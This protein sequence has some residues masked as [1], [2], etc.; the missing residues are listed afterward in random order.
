MKIS[1]T[2]ENLNKGLLIVGHIAGKNINLPIL[3][4]IF[5]KAKEKTLTVSA[6]NLEIGV[7]ADIRSKVE[8]NG[9][10]TVD[11]KLLSDYI[12]LLPQERIDLS[13]EE[14]YLK[15]NCQGQ[16]TK[17][18]TQDSTDFPLIP[19]V[20]KEKGYIVL[21][22]DFKTA[23][24][25]VSFATSSSET[26][27]EISG[28]Y[29]LFDKKEITLAATDSYRLAENKIKTIESEGEEKEIIIPVKTLLEISRILGL[30]KDDISTEG[31]NLMIYILE[32]QIMFSYNGIDVVSRLIEGQYPDYKQIIPEKFNTKIKVDKNN[33]LKSVKRAALFTKSGIYDVKM[34]FKDNNIIVSS[35]SSQ[36]GENFSEVQCDIEGQNNNIVLNYRY[37][38]DGLQNID[39]ENI[40]MEI[41]DSNSP[42]IIKPENNNNY[43]YIIMPIKQ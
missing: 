37:L 29:M 42:C 21:A 32:N 36:T 5:I 1:C 22:E 9:E 17:I 38:L 14:N 2:Q 13:T 19:K 3:S 18:N 10:I 33:L 12:S 40:L 27:P 41:I 16:R 25:E 35:S 26:R 43:I 24:S 34:E 28:V 39:S 23:V 30:F 4:N 6:T 31:N 20:K 15:I 7:T 8:E 11:A